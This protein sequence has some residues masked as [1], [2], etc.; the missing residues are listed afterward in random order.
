MNPACTCFL[1]VGLPGSGKSTWCQNFHPDLKIVSRDIIRA[2]LG[3]SSN[4]DEKV[5]LSK[6]QEMEITKHEYARID[7]FIENHQDFIIDD[8]NTSKYRQ[9]LIARLRSKNVKVIGVK[10]TCPLEICIERRK[11]Q[12]PP[13]IMRVL[14]DRMVPLDRCEVDEMVEYD[15]NK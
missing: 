14:A 8:T 2:E 6:E 10:M 1:L 11:G 15:S 7:S 9:G 5:R 3:Y 12:I 13:D 4:A